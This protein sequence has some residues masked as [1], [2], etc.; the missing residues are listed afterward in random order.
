MRHCRQRRG[1]AAHRPD[2]LKKSKFLLF[3]LRKA[4]YDI[5]VD[6]LV[7]AFVAAD[8]AVLPTLVFSSGNLFRSLFS[9]TIERQQ[10]FL[11]EPE[12]F[13][14]ISRKSRC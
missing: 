6:V 3:S 13:P 9:L 8:V 11:I 4:D 10:G 1:K 5:K 12:D 2:Y 7:F 14:T